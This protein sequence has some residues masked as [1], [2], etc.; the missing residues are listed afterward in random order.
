ML[1]TTADWKPQNLQAVRIVGKAKEAPEGSAAA[2]SAGL[3]VVRAP[4]VPYPE[5]WQDGPILLVGVND[6]PAFFEMT[7]DSDPIALAR[8]MAD[9]SFALKIKRVKPEFKE[10]VTL[11]KSELPPEWSATNK[12]DKDTMTIN[13]KHPVVAIN[14][15]VSLKFWWYGNLNGRGQIVASET[16]VRLFEPLQVVVSALPAV[17][18]GEMQKLAIEVKREGGEPQPVVLKFTGLPAGTTAAESV[19]IPAN[20]SKVEV[21]I[22]AAADAAVG[23]ASVVVNAVSKLGDKETTASMPVEIAVVE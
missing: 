4:F 15:P 1:Q 20:E 22:S 17:K 14:E 21:P 13:V 23:K 2:T 8:P 18:R 9:G 19:T 16:K 12:L 5:P 11:I 10:G 3:V 7:A 6:E